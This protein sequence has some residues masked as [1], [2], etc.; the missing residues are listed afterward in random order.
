MLINLPF[1]K[2][3]RGFWQP[4]VKFV[5]AVTGFWQPSDDSATGIG[6]VCND[7]IFVRKFLPYGI[8]CP[9]E[10]LPETIAKVSSH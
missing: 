3:V 8:G 2:I 10:Q 6:N 5:T 4:S 7:H 9:I 1:G